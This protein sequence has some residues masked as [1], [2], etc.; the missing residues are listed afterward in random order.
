M[1]GRSSRREMAML[2]MH[3]HIFTN[4]MLA[5]ILLCV[6]CNHVANAGAFIQIV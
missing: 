1:R 5:G 3:G 4:I 2:A 6:A